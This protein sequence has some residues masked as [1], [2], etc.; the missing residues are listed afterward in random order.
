[1]FGIATSCSRSSQDVST[2]GGSAGLILSFLEREVRE[3]KR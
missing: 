3:R 2:I 1:M